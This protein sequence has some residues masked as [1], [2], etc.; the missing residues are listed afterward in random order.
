MKAVVHLGQNYIEN[1]NTYK[2]T[3]FE[4]L[5]IIFD[6]TQKSILNHDVEILN[7]STIEWTFLFMGDIHFTKRQSNQVDESKDTRLLSFSTLSWKDS[8][9]YGSKC[10]VERTTSRLPTVQRE[11]GVIWDRWR[12]NRVGVNFFMDLQ[13][14]RFSKRFTSNWKLV[15]QIQK[16]LKIESSSCPCSMIVIE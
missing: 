14:Y 1:L 4:E 7:V 15:K 8:R 16:K 13:R 5:K 10:K 3:N 6:I 2:N 12:F 9:V 11:Q